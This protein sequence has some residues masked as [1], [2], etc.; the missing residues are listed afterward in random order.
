MLDVR[1]LDQKGKF[2][3]GVDNKELKMSYIVVSNIKCI[4][5][6][7]DL[8]FEED[9]LD[10]KEESFRE[11]L[12]ELIAKYGFDFK[13]IES[14]FVNEKKYSVCEC[15]KCGHLMINRDKNPIGYDSENIEDV[16][17]NGGDYE[18]MTMCEECLPKEH[19]W[20]LG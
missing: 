14:L 8:E 17:I 11:D 18:G 10:E 4:T 9:V 6:I 15:E 20:G 7:S 19:R 2:T 16:V 12:R 5:K 1:A 3:I 13:F